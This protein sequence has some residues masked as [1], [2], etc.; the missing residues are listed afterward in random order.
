M[1]R[2]GVRGEGARPRVRQAD[3]LGW[4]DSLYD[5]N[6]DPTDGGGA[7]GGRGGDSADADGRGAGRDGRPVDKDG[8]D[9]SGEPRGQGRHGGGGGRRR[10][11]G[12]G[13]HPRRRRRILRW[14]ASVLALLILG[15]A[16]AGYL[17]YQHLSANIKKDD[18]NLGD[19][20]DRAAKSKA[21]AAGQTP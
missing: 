12:D 19:E 5:E 1:A 17:Y 2:S 4:D 18:L 11:S 9:A 16:G 10:G 15:T 8:D 3:D 20:K 13:G 21:N 7:S 6:G 14:S